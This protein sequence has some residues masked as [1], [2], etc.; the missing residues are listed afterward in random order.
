MSISIGVAKKVCPY[1]FVGLVSGLLGC[2]ERAPLAAGAER[3][4]MAKAKS[5]RR[6]APTTPSLVIRAVGDHFEIEVTATTPFPP[7]GLG[8]ILHVGSSTFG[9]FVYS[10][11]AGFYG[12]VFSISAA[13]FALLSDGDA[14]YVDHGGNSVRQ[15]FGV[16]DRSKAQ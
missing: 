16:L 8:P 7:A 5:Q 15:Q 11:S 1:V 4:V 6:T 10:P 13:E 3:T 14:V 9:R 12:L 2:N